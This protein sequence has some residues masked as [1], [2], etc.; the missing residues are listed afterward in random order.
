[1]KTLTAKEA[2]NKQNLAFALLQLTQL[3]EEL[4]SDRKTMSD[5]AD[6]GDVTALRLETAITKLVILQTDMGF[7]D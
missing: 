1:M 7:R 6:S 3:R 5:A 2:T 4:Y